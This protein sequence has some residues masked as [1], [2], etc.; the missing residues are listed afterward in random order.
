[1]RNKERLPTE[2]TI[3]L[4]TQTGLPPRALADA[5]TAM[6]P[7]GRI[8][9]GIDLLTGNIE[10]RLYYDPDILAQAKSW[11]EEQGVPYDITFL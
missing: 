5:L 9:L 11:L 10:L 6:L 8:E 2:M 7:A 3:F 1:M 4:P